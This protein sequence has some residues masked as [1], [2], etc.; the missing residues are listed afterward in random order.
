M[1]EPLAVRLLKLGG[2][3][4]GMGEPLAVRL[5]KL[6]GWGAGMGEPLRI[7]AEAEPP[8]L[9]DM[10]LTEPITGSTIR[11]ASTNNASLFKIFFMDEPS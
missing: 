2:W 3:G 11:L 10:V 1:G 9:L 7:A 5:L 4:A 6:G 8:R